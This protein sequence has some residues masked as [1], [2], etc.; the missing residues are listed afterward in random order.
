MRL[1][2][3]ARGAGFPSR[4]WR[5]AAVSVAPTTSPREVGPPMTEFLH[6]AWDLGAGLWPY[7]V[8]ALDLAIALAAS[9]HAVLYKRD[10][11][12][13]VAWVG[14]IWLVPFLGALLYLLFGVNRIR[15]R[16][17]SLRAG[18]PHPQPPPNPFECAVSEVAPLLGPEAAHLTTLARVV[19]AATGRPLLRGNHLTPLRNGEEAYRRCT[20]ASWTPVSRWSFR[21]DGCLE[22]WP[23]LPSRRQIPDSGLFWSILTRPLVNSRSASCRLLVP[24]MR[25]P[26]APKIDETR[27]PD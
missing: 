15:R 3:A 23:S 21:A 17:R 18:R 27:N 26:I 24:S 11:R 14:L 5:A 16:A 1:D 10:A 25:S 19:A 8:T 9:G 2:P 20:P 4:G 12:A 22:N 13:A 6:G 7:L